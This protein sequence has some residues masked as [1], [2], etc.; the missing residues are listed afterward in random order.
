MLSLA[1]IREGLHGPVGFGRS[2]RRS[3][4]PAAPAGAEKLRVGKAVAQDFGF[5]PLDVGIAHGIFKKQG[6]EIEEFDFAGGAKQQQAIVAGGIDI[7]LG[8]GTDMAF[9]PRARPTIAVAAITA[10]P[11]FMGFIVGADL[12]AQA[13]RRP[14]GQEDRRHHRRL[15]HRWLVD[16]AEP[17]QGLGR[18][19]RGAGARSAASSR[20]RSRRSRPQAVDAFVEA[21]AIGYPARDE[22]AGGCSSPSRTM[23]KDLEIFI[24]LRRT[25]LI[26]QNP[27]AV[28]RF[29]KG[30]FETVAYMKKPQGRDRR[31]SRAR[32][33]ATRQP[34]EEREYD[35]LM[36]YFSTDGKFDQKALE[37]L[38][39][40]LRRSQDARHGARHDEALYR[41]VP[42]VGGRPP[43]SFDFGL[44]LQDEGRGR[45]VLILAERRSA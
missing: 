28:R 12:P 19:R 41:A 8:G 6:L 7:A 15:A 16:R 18:R 40:I 17:R 29:L 35:L 1:R 36:P 45:T 21:P 23:C 43:A 42:A 27:D 20:P 39:A 13:H 11:A 5:V 34:V 37:A 25:A 32:S 33:P 4:P 14:E 22:Q 38:R 30:W 26:Q 9:A 31:R 44:R 3:S 24:I 10:S 2:P